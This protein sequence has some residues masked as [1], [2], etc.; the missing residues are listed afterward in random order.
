MI[1]VRGREF[2]DPP[3]EIGGFKMIDVF[4]AKN[5][6]ETYVL[7][8]PKHGKNMGKAVGTVCVSTAF[9]FLLF[10]TTNT[11]GWKTL[12]LI[13]CSNM[14]HSNLPFV[15]LPNNP[16]YLCRVRVQYIPP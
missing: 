6:S 16:Y 2:S 12:I 10:K 4:R 9:P 3:I 11:E 13:Q 1:D 8:F 14:S 7:K 15:Q 5:L